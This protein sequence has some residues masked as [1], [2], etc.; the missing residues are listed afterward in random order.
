M[1]ASKPLAALALGTVLFG[2]SS[3]GYVATLET[4][5]DVE[6]VADGQTLATGKISQF[7]NLILPSAPEKDGY[8]FY[9]YFAGDPKE[10]NVSKADD[11]PRAYKEGGLLRFNDVKS[12]VNGNKLT[13]NGIYLTPEEIPHAYLVIGW[14]D[15]TSTSGL[16]QEDLDRWTPHARSFV[17][18]WCL[19]QGQSEE[20][21]LAHSLDIDIRPY[22][23]NGNV[24]ALG[25]GVNKDGDVD[26]LLGV[27]NN[28]DSES[29][30]NIAIEEKDGNIPMN[31]KS[32][33]I[34]R[35]T[36]RPEVVA[37]YNW[38][39]TAEGYGPLSK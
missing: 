2:L 17:E 15:K 11:D 13:V 3:C 30:A 37:I 10:F 31:G 20:D 38:L 6:V 23:N 34:A 25:A 35:L 1:K 16:G 12:Y 33:Y 9:R 21:A 7:N 32:R 18:Q 29:G 27:G 22:S 19:G 4:F 14:Y 24:A 5:V 36:S 28:V 39:K 26:I 8:K